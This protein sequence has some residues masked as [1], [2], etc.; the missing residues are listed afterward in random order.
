MGCQLDV[1]LKQKTPPNVPLS[2]RGRGREAMTYGRARIVGHG[3]TL[4]GAAVS[5][6]AELV[7]GHFKRRR[8]PPHPPFGHPL[9]KGRSA[10]RSRS[11]NP[12]GHANSPRRFRD[13]NGALL[14]ARKVYMGL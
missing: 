4:D 9:P 7:R 11:A 10:S 13:G 1:V 5:H 2:P 14:D 8:R 6:S 12:P 3:H